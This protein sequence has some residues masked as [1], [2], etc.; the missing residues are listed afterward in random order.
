MNDQLLGNFI[1]NFFEK[2]GKISLFFEQQAVELWGQTVGEYVNL[3]TQK[4]IANKGILYVTIPNA[5]LRFEI[6]NSRTQII[7][8]INETLG[9]E[10]IKGIIVK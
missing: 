10:V 5:A 4:I 1:Q 9:T 6:L 3:Q 2:N 8:K 7:N